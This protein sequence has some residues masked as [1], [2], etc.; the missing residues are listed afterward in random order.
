MILYE[1]SMSKQQ[2]ILGS[3]FTPISFYASK[4]TEVCKGLVVHAI[5]IVLK[6]IVIWKKK[7][8]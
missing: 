4:P 5:T 6:S 7:V 1:I 2:K 8:R 3:G